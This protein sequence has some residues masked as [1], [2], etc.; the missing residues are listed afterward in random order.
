MT[1]QP[2]L[3]LGV[4]V[5][6]IVVHDHIGLLFQ[7]LRI[8]RELESLC[9][10]RLQI[11]GAPD[12]VDR[13][14]A[15]APALRHGPATPVGRPRRLGLQDRI[16]DS[17]APVDLIR[18]L[19]SPSWSNVPQTIQSLRYQGVFATEFRPV[20]RHAH[21]NPGRRQDRA[22]RPKSLRHHPHQPAEPRPPV[23]R[24]PERS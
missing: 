3:D 11:V 1:F 5:R 10:M 4:F 9:A 22:A 21:T 2:R 12:I 17:G 15:D 16:H 13:G 23:M 20:S 7:K 6:P 19:L 14:L 24:R 8:A 18:G